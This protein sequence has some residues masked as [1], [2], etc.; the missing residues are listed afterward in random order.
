MAIAALQ[1]ATP[2]AILSNINL[3][4]PWEVEIKIPN[5]S[6]NFPATPA[7]GV[8]DYNVKITTIGCTQFSSG[9][10]QQKAPLH[11]IRVDY[12]ADKSGMAVYFSLGS[13][14][15]SSSP[16]LQI[17]SQSSI[18]DLDIVIHAEPTGYVYVLINGVKTFETNT[19]VNTPPLIEVD[20]SAYANTN[21]NLTFAINATVD[22]RQLPALTQLINTIVGVGVGLGLVGLA[23]QLIGKMGKQS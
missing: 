21:A 22:V 2:T 4:A 16:E 20:G 19:Y 18:S 5:P 17:Y 7:Q 1:N 8:T 14:Y 23:T 15:T 6:N 9:T 13:Y 3:Q 11:N 10:C 12:K